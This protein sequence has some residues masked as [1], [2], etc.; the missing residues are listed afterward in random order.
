MLQH[1]PV[2]QPHEPLSH[3]HVGPQGHPALALAEHRPLAQPHLPV[4]Q[5]QSPSVQAHAGPQVHGIF[6]VAEK[7]S[8]RSS[9]G[10][11]CDTRQGVKTGL[12][13]GQL[14][15]IARACFG[16]AWRTPV[17]SLPGAPCA[18]SPNCRSPPAAAV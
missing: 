17:V 14:T 7:R 16:D 8:R 3:L 9:Q 2:A 6:D 15:F 11:V 1:L 4:E 10:S 5:P 13:F 18:G 12:V